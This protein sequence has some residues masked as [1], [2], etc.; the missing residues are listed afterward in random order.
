MGYIPDIGVSLS[1]N[2]LQQLFTFFNY[3]DLI[4]CSRRSTSGAEGDNQH[5]KKTHN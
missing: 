1:K 4:R 5:K 3:Y 2:K